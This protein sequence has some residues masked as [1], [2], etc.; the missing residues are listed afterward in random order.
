[1]SLILLGIEIFANV[2]ARGLITGFLRYDI[3]LGVWQSKAKTCIGMGDNICL[4]ATSC[5]AGTV[6]V[7]PFIQS[8]RHWCGG[9]TYKPNFLKRRRKVSYLRR[10]K[11]LTGLRI[12]QR[13]Q[14][15]GRWYISH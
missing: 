10:K 11:T 9:Q 12:L 14:L 1:M 4:Y 5:S 15:K 2:F 6:S 8:V 7:T 3:F 13:R